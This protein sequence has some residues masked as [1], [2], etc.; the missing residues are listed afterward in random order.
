M[1]KRT[2]DYREGLLKSLL[3]PN[4]AA[5][6]V[7]AALEDSDEMFLVAL[8]DVAE[9]RQVAKVAVDAGLSRESIYRT[10]SE[11][12]NP[13]FSS[14]IG[15]LKAVGLKLAIEPDVQSKPTFQFED[16]TYRIYLSGFRSAQTEYAYIQGISA[17]FQTQGQ[18][19]RGTISE[20]ME[21]SSQ[22]LQQHERPV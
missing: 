14:L 2:R 22:F 7:N 16:Q 8:R 6:Y 1:P 21:H 3:D 10:L 11:N 5:Q 19:H 15:I 13:R 20:I 9:A 12:G 18:R 4:A 17:Y